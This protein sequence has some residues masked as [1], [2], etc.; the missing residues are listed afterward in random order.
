MLRGMLGWA[1]LGDARQSERSSSHQM[2][3]TDTD[4]CETWGKYEGANDT[5]DGV[6]TC[7]ILFEVLDINKIHLKYHFK[8]TCAVPGFLAS[9][10]EM[11][12]HA[13]TAGAGRL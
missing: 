10:N 9:A 4:T 5:R 1:G 7:L 11:L 12:Q 2:L 6:M 13:H 8:E 3:G